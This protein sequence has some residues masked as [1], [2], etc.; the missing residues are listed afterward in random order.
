M[1]GVLVDI[2]RCYGCGSC[3]VACKLY[4]G[5]NWD[6]ASPATGE[7]AVLTAHNWTAVET[8]RIGRD[9]G[10]LLRFVKKQCLHCLEPICFETCFVHAYRKTPEGPVIYAHPEI[11]VGCRYCQLAC[12]FL[13]VGV[14]WEDVFSRIGKCPMCYERVKDGQPPACVE[15]CPTKAL[16]FG[17]RGALLAMARERIKKHPDRYVDHIFGEK[18]VGGTSWLYISDIA[19]EELGFNTNLM[20]KSIPQYTWKYVSK[21]PILAVGLP[22]AFAALYTYTKRRTENE[23]SGH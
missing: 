6:E 23:E 22:I 21:A 1:N 17:K 16:E 18:E 15:A 20:H 3:A 13:V 11:C 19:F 2:T 12:P 5:L 9:E 7:K 10:K 8:R 14:E 4:N